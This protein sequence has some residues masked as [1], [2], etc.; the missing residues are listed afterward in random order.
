MCYALPMTQKLRIQVPVDPIEVAKL[1]TIAKQ[2]QVS[3]AQVV[4]WAIHEYLKAVALVALV[5]IACLLI[6]PAAQAKPLAT[7]ATDI[8]HGQVQTFQAPD[9]DGNTS[10]ALVA[11]F[12][13]GHRMLGIADHGAVVLTGFGIAARVDN[14]TVVIASLG[15]RGHVVISWSLPETRRTAQRGPTGYAGVWSI[16][17]DQTTFP[18]R[19]VVER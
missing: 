10:R 3:L 9:L 5:T 14:K 13:N 4:R 1:R 19:P 15:G 18:N 12:V 2:R 11:G 17:P 16:F 8:R 6:A 7:Q